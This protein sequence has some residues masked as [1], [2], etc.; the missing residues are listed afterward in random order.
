MTIMIVS[1]TSLYVHRF[2][3]V[4][5]S[6]LSPPAC[7]P[8]ASIA[9]L[10]CIPPSLSLSRFQH[11]PTNRRFRFRCLPSIDLLVRTQLTSGCWTHHPFCNCPI[12][13]ARDAVFFT[14]ATGPSRE[15][16]VTG[17]NHRILPNV[18]FG[19]ATDF[20]LD[21]CEDLN[22]EA[23]KLLNFFRSR[24]KRTVLHQVCHI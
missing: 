2:F 6:T 1:S 20:Q 22:T 7:L 10:L 18:R 23:S 15:P 8:V 12:G 17:I 14:A 16:C 5:P 4:F 11:L 19:V 3:T 21:A 13:T 9:S 24:T